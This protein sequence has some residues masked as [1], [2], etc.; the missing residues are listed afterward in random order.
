M[1]LDEA[2]EILT[3]AGFLLETS[4]KQKGEEFFTAF[5]IALKDN[6]ENVTL[7]KKLKSNS[8]AKYS[9]NTKEYHCD[10]ELEFDYGVK[11]LFDENG[12]VEAGDIYAWLDFEDGY[13]FYDDFFGADEIDKII[14]WI[15]AS[16]KK[17]K[18]KVI[19]IQ[20]KKELAKQEELAKKKPAV[21]K[22]RVKK[23][24]YTDLHKYKSDIYDALTARGLNSEFAMDYVAGLDYDFMKDNQDINKLAD[25]AVREWG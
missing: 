1:N 3:K 15:K 22:P 16:S 2:K 7:V 23:P 20:K 18:E 21:K 13:D 25:E 10:L 8:K 5:E 19:E 12:N 24:K 11:G 9:F 4:R 6:F 17:D 14:N